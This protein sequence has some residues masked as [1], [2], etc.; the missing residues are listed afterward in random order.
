M[1]LVPLLIVLLSA[2]GHAAWNFLAKRSRNKLVFIWGLYAASP[3]LFLPLGLWLGMGGA[4]G[5]EGWLCIVASGL[6][7]G[8]YI[9]FLAEALT[10]GDLS[11]A[12]PLSRIAPAIV[13]IWAVL[14]LGESL[15]AAGLAGIALV[16]LAIFVIHLEGF[17]R[18]HLLRLRAAMRTR[19]TAFALLAALGVSTY[20]VIDKHA[21]ANVRLEP[22]PFNL[23]HWAIGAALLAPYVLWRCGRPAVG[24]VLRAEWPTILVAALLDFGSYLLVLFVLETSKVSYVVAARQTSQI[25][26]ILL[27][28]L[29]LKERCGRVRLI[30]GGMILTGVAV[31][32]LA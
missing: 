10:A 21:M 29:L 15:S 32:S 17:G 6:A 1:A 24:A 26:A 25:V 18:T 14:F 8:V 4:I 23:Y 12:Y 20:S 28:T 2:V 30:A 27:G 19:A 16:C 7:K 3:V 9:V 31:I 11:V 5:A 22:L 13:P